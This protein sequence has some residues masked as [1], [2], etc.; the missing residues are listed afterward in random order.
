[1]TNDDIKYI[2]VHCS[3]TKPHQHI[4]VE[5]IRKWHKDRGWDDVGYHFV[6]RR[7]GTVEAGRPLNVAGAHV[8]GW[9][10]CTWGICLVGGL[11]AEGHAVDNFTSD[12]KEMLK[13]LI[14]YLRWR[15]PR[16]DVQGHRDFPDVHKDCPCFDVRKW[17][18]TVREE[19]M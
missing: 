19:A 9:N 3:A 8:E 17:Y 2:V 18:A 4:G 14:E 15:A 13:Y 1:M 5:E 16:A 12:Q 7:N 6:I 10:H 11:D